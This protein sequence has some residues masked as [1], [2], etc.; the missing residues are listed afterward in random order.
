[1][2]CDKKCEFVWNSDEGKKVCKYTC[3]LGELYPEG[4][5][6]IHNRSHLCEVHNRLRVRRKMRTVM[7][8]EEMDCMV[9]EDGSS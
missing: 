3:C 2:K 6:S 7:D 5:F 9:L 4:T 8:D 1:M